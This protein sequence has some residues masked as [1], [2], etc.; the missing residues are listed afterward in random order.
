[1]EPFNK[2]GTLK[3]GNKEYDE[4]KLEQIRAIL[5]DAVEEMV[6]MVFSIFFNMS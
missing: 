4:F 6:I 2:K 5:L 1:M 3:T